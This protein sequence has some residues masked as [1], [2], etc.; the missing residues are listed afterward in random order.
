VSIRFRD[1]VLSAQGAQHLGAIHIGHGPRFAAIA[2]ASLLFA[3]ALIAFAVLAELTRKARL[4]GILVPTLG[5]LDLSTPHGGR[6]LEIHAKEG[7]SVDT[8]QVVMRIGTDRSTQLGDTS[9]LVMK[10]LIQRRT[11]LQAERQSAARQAQQRA[12]ALSARLQSMQTEQ[13]QA[14]D[15]LKALQR[16][17]ELAH[18]TVDR[19]DRLAAAG[20]VSA[21][22]VQQ[23]HEELLDLQL[24]E[25][26]AQRALT[27]LA[28]EAG[29]V[30]AEQV[31]I[32][33][34]LRTQLAQLDR[35]LAALDQ[36]AFEVNG[37][38]EVTI[39]A[40]QPGTIT[41]LAL[42]VGQSVQ[43]GQTLA[44]LVPRSPSGT[45]SELEA[46]LYAPSR[47]IGFVQPGQAVWLRYAAYP[48]QKFGLA[49]ARIVSVSRTPISPQDLPVGQGQA[50]L[51]SVR[52]PEPLYRVT[53]TLAAQ[54][55]QTY[56]T[57]QRLKPG[58][59]L[60]AEVVQDR[61]ALWEWLLDPLLAATRGKATTDAPTG[62]IPST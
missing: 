51:Q 39:V 53:A 62:R 61:R 26:A 52:S 57:P 48:Y 2:A 21:V 50:L 40:P 42:H 5:A 37:R 34:S 33:T 10:S 18:T 14:K 6:L 31:G 54:V 41:A 28:R 27:A 19:F 47:T 24:R 32:D 59:A 7:D 38:S 30:R 29:M 46:H 44:T 11:T 9:S 35:M 49:S 55:I 25:R 56:G 23:K 43:P 13:L 12:E 4:P 22:T 16:R 17:I 58:M 15:E 1:E 20:F 36:E 45:L 60:D 8:G 3:I